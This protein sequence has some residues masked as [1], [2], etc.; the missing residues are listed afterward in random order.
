MSLFDI[1]LNIFEVLPRDI[2]NINQDTLIQAPLITGFFYFI[3]RWF[4]AYVL[5]LGLFIFGSLIVFQVFQGQSFLNRF[6]FYAGLGILLPHIP[7]VELT[8][9]ILRERFLF[10]YGKILEL[11]FLILSPFVWLYDVSRNMFGFLKT[12]HDEK[13]NQQSYE[14][15]YHDDFR[16]QQKEEWE[17]EQARQDEKDQREFREQEEKRQHEKKEQHR[18]YEEQKKQ[19]QEAKQKEKNK[20][21]SRWDSDSDHEILGIEET[22][23]KDEIKKAYRR[24]ARIYHPDLALLNK[25]EAEEIFKKINNAYT[26]LS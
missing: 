5:R 8:Y 3:S 12:K 9:L 11:F 26:R 20:P 6:D 7:I 25:E 18:K 1:I 13:V 16:N 21:K 22:A 14:K 2:A 24:L 10:M 4:R 15:Y 23:T 19:Y 17:K